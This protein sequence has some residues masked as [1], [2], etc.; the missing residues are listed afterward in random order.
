MRLGR[1]QQALGLIVSKRGQHIPGVMPLEPRGDGAEAVLVVTTFLAASM[2]GEVGAIV[3]RAAR[4]KAKRDSRKHRKGGK[5]KTRYRNP[6]GGKWEP[7]R[8]R[9]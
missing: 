4:R 1:G 3:E 7:S 9:A 6:L 2:A 8:W 5:A